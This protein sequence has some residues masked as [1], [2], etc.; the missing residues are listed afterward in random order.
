MRAAPVPA[1][2]RPGPFGRVRA[3]SAAVILLCWRVLGTQ[4]ATAGDEAS[5][6][7][8]DGSSTVFP[9]SEAAA[10][11]FQIVQ[12]DT[13][14]TVAISGTGGGFTHF[15]AGESD[16]NNASRPISA[17]EADLAALRSISYVET[18][19]A[20]DGLTVAVHPRNDWVDYLTVTELR[21]IWSVDSP[22][23]R[24]SD[25]RP[26]WPARE[27]HLYAPGP[28]SGSFDYFTEAILGRP[29]AARP[30]HVS[31]EDDNVLAQGIAA[32]EDALGYFGYT[33]YLQY[34]N[35]IRPVPIDG[36]SGPVAPTAAS[37]ENATYRPLS[38]ILLLY[39]R[40]AALSRSEVAA[41]VDFYLRHARVFVASVGAIPLPERAY[42]LG[43][44]RMRALCAGS[45]F[46]GKTL[47]AAEVL[48]VLEEHR[49][50][51]GGDGTG[52]A[53]TSTSRSEVAFAERGAPIRQAGGVEGR[54]SPEAR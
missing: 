4:A 31:H 51:A 5:W 16:I 36:G 14:V 38:R 13:R 35:R 22:A 2:T 41:F 40:A 50:C 20:R 32:D 9:I 48:R 45:L 28:A 10:D 7:R 34:K 52:A 23:R 11:E 54:R 42:E 44:H 33:Y 46:A 49:D 26:D 15:L 12:Q 27:M 19:I 6:V 25:L 53:S 8:I 24:W 47:T 43:R 18:P 3:L 1:G 37:I 30:N 17:A 21:R 39:V 29:A